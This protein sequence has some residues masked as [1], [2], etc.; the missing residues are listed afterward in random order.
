MVANPL[1][2]RQ[3]ED[4]TPVKPSYAF[5]TPAQ[6]YELF[7]AA[8][9]AEHEIEAKEL[10]TY[11]KHQHLFNAWAIAAHPEEGGEEETFVICCELQQH[12]EP[13]MPKEGRHCCIKL[14]DATTKRAKSTL[15]EATRI[16][17]YYGKFDNGKQ[18]LK[19]HAFF[20]ITLALS[21]NGNG[22]LEPLLPRGGDI[23]KVTEIALTPNN[24]TTIAFHFRVN[25]AT[26]QAELSALD[27]IYR[28][29][30]D[31]VTL[32]QR[33]A[34]RY[35]LK[36][37]SPE[38]T[39]SLFD[40]W[41]KLKN[42]LQQA[43]LPETLANKIRSFN[44]H[45]KAAYDEMLDRLPCGVGILPGGPGAGKT[46]WGL[47]T[48]GTVQSLYPGVSV[49]YLLDINKPL[50]D[51]LIKYL[52]MCK[53]AGIYKKA[54]RMK[55]F[56]A[57]LQG[58]SRFEQVKRQAKKNAGIEEEEPPVDFS[59]TFIAMYRAG[60][61]HRTG[62]DG[63]ISI[64]PTLDEA[65][66]RH[67]EANLVKYQRLTQCLEHSC[68]DPM[69]H[70]MLKMQVYRLYQDVLK[71]ADFIA[72]TP[73]VAS[74]AFHDMFK[75]DIVILDEAAHCR[76]LTSLIAIA[77]FSP[78]TWLFVGDYRQTL[79]YCADK[80]RNR[81]S[82]Q[83]LISMMERAHHQGVISHQLLVNH[84]AYGGLERLP[85][86]IIYEGK[87]VTGIKDENR[88][89]P[90][91]RFTQQYLERFLHGEKC[92]TPRLFV[93]VQN[94]GVEAVRVGTSWH[95][96][97]HREWV[98]RRVLELTSNPE[99]RSA[100][101]ASEPG[102]M[103]LLSPYKQAV[104]QYAEAI[105][106]LDRANPDLGIAKRIEARTWDT[107]Q[108]S[109]ADFVVIDY[110]RDVVTDFMDGMHRFNVGLTR[111]RQGEFHIASPRIVNSRSFWKT[112]YV[113]KLYKACSRGLDGVKYGHVAVT[114]RTD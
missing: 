99:F 74:T 33:Q 43:G 2:P 77:N 86:K 66:W 4:T 47:T 89:P 25:P 72:T 90:Q 49:L 21:P 3:P 51:T 7:R 6:F 24:A 60:G 58:S 38:S 30:P 15:W 106:A 28:A 54:I 67:Y 104:R 31:K 45:Q 85:S 42:P 23:S 62:D 9:L 105:K 84:R 100:E 44:D 80:E 98:M 68:G 46:H 114:N 8:T 14:V 96:P 35:I 87:M 10:A 95:H 97:A 57:E 50:D 75:P 27:K 92:E 53:T 83:L 108:G 11:N 110:V 79:P 102:T 82:P 69:G 41:P 61:A 16:G 26:A 1:Q 113:V 36:F 34:F 19:N 73:C 76:E 56:G 93:K 37:D 91:A 101:D 88:F 22:L 20:K 111:A 59:A 71:G 109:E 81:Y 94:E 107:S 52:R 63:D 39:E 48:V 103:L 55:S 5:E 40:A 12:V 112:Q 17:N 78:K 29:E 64:I 70:A 13:F 32:R 18:E 65:A